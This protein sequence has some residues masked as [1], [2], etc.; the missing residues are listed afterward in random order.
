MTAKQK[1]DSSEILNREAISPTWFIRYLPPIVENWPNESSEATF[2]PFSSVVT[3]VTWSCWFC[4]DSVAL[5][6]RGGAGGIFGKGSLSGGI[7]PLLSSL[8]RPI[9]LEVLCKLR[10]DL[11]PW[12]TGTRVFAAIFPF[13]SRALCIPAADSQKRKLRRLQGSKVQLEKWR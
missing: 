12:N 10:S 7:A 4:H 9:C 3:C 11:Q 8:F 1:D 13:A 6:I 2:I 5:S